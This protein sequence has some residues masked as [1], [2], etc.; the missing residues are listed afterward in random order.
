MCPLKLP[1][2]L[3]RPLTELTFTTGQAVPAI[4]SVYFSEM[5]MDQTGTEKREKM[6]HSYSFKE[7]ETRIVDDVK[8]RRE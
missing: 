6:F 8:L 5:S 7:E 2:I 4:K 3:Q 1:I